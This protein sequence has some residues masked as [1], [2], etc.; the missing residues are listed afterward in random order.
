MRIATPDPQNRDH[1]LVYE[2]LTQVYNNLGAVYEKQ[3][4]EKKEAGATD[5]V[6]DHLREEALTHYW[7]SVETA[8]RIDLPAEIPRQNIQLGFP[9]NG[10]RD[11]LLDE[12]LSPLLEKSASSE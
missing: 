5:A 8:G 3:Y 11:P 1:K 7:K 2:Q 12:W 4:M 10:K 6:L 9:R